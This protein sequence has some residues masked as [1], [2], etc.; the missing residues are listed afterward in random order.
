[1]KNG[2]VFLP[3][4]TGFVFA[5]V[6]GDIVYWL[7]NPD[8]SMTKTSKEKNAIGFYISTKAVSAPKREDLT[9]DYKHPEGG[10]VYMLSHSVCSFFLACHFLHVRFFRLLLSRN[11]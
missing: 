8:G 6:N 1:M 5:E 10:C 11:P 9:L 7:V 4:D 3:Y 2:E